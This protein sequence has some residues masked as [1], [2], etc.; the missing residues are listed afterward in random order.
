MAEP[1]GRQ[2]DRAEL[3]GLRRELRWWKNLFWAALGA[4]I[5]VSAFSFMKAEQLS[6]R[7]DDMEKESATLIALESLSLAKT[8][9]DELVKCQDAL[10]T[11][12]PVVRLQRIEPM[13]G[14]AA[15]VETAGGAEEP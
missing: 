9:R 14:E 11:L 2:D 10:I 7:L 6:N 1:S 4:V 5:L 13:P 3:D 15:T 8:A 12:I